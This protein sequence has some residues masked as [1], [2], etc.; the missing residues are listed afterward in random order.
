MPRCSATLAFLLYVPLEARAKE[1]WKWV[2]K[3]EF[4]AHTDRYLF[5]P[6]SIARFNENLVLASVVG[7]GESLSRGKEA[8]KGRWVEGGASGRVGARPFP[9]RHLCR[10]LYEPSA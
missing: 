6:S 9:I 1:G 5:S 8:G 10:S 7:K 2:N 4:L 3:D